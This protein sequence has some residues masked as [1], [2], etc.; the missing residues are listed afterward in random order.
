MSH[1][2]HTA[3]AG[4]GHNGGP[5]LTVNGGPPL[6]AAFTINEFCVAHRI[7]RASLYNA[8]AEGWGPAFMNIGK[9]RIIS[10]E[11]AARWRAEGEARA[12]QKGAGEAA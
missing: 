10:L 1:T 2:D 4:I 9:K 7:C 12:R 8:W 3:P 11:A 5:P 6:R